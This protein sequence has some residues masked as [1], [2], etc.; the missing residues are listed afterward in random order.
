[1]EIQHIKSYGCSKNSTE[2]K[3][4]AINAYTKNLQ[5]SKKKKT[6]SLHLKKLEK[7]QIKLKVRKRN[8]SE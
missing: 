6:L 8:R 7:E 1:M 4:I 5:R 2:W 3:F